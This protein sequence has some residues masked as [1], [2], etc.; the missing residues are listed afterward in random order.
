MSS[1][2]T[3][4]LI[5]G[6][7]FGG[8]VCGVFL[9]PFLDEHHLNSDSKEIFSGARGVIVGLAALT[10]GLLVSSAKTS[11]DAKSDELK[12]QAANLIL[13]DRVLIDYGPKANVARTAV[14]HAI[15]EEINQVRR[16]NVEGAD[17]RSEIGAGRLEELRP[18]LLNLASSNERES[19]LKTTSLS[20][21]QEIMASRWRIYEDLAS[22][23]QWPIVGVLVVWLCSI[24]FSF[25]VITPRNVLAFGGL[26]VASASMAGA[27]FLI[28]EMDEA[29][30]G[31]ITVS[32]APLET[33]LQ[34]V[35]RSTAQ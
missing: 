29:Y 35:S 2:Q 3:S 5:F 15:Q 27:M 33:A 8:A 32:A 12:K 7:I 16:A 21:C 30:Q 9:Q 20:L 23:I 31:Y 6:F 18:T 34:K 19:W 22:D 24:F 1:L 11:F 17:V 4:L 25:G 13:L 10:L 26:F 28:L 14:A